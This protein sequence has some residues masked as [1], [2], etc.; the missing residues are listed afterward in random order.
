MELTLQNSTST[1]LGLII[2]TA[3]S[4]TERGGDWAVR[5]RPII[6]LQQAK[7]GF[8]FGTT[9]HIS[10]PFPA[11]NTSNPFLQATTSCWGSCSHSLP[12]KFC[13]VSSLENSST[14]NCWEIN[15]ASKENSISQI[16]LTAHRPPLWEERLHNHLDFESNRQEFS[17]RKTFFLYC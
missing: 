7:Q 17:L 1:L 6:W 11:E 8:S 10:L 5:H 2:T 4:E 12:T 9:Q 3:W 14:K 13:I 15:S 16:L